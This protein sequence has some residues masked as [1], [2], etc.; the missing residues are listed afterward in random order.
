MVIGSTAVKQ[1]PK[2][3]SVPLCRVNKKKTKKKTKIEDQ[4]KLKQAKVQK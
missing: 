1:K 2:H 4:A 3:S